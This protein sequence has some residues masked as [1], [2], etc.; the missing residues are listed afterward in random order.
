MRLTLWEGRDEDGPR[1]VLARRD[2]FNAAMQEVLRKLARY[3]D[4]EER[5]VEDA[6][7]YDEDGGADEDQGR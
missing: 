2:N 1:A 5:A 7:P 3:E 4:E 6:G